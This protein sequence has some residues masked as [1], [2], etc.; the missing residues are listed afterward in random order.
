MSPDEQLA[1]EKMLER[2]DKLTEACQALSA[3]VADGLIEAVAEIAPAINRFNASLEAV[4]EKIPSK[5]EW[6]DGQ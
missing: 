6:L 3:A 2:I 1:F 4:N 5:D